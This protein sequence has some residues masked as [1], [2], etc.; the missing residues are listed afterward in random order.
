MKTIIIT[1]PS[2]SGKTFL[3]NKL[4]KLFKNSIV[5]KTDS[6]YRDNFLIKFLSFFIDDIYDRIISIKYYELINTIN[7]IESESNQ[8]ELYYYEFKSKRSIKFKQKMEYHKSEKILIIEGIF[9]HRL[10]I[11]YNDTLNIICEETKEICYKRRLNRDKLERGRSIFEVKKKF[12]KSWNLYFK[13]LEKIINN[14][15]L[16]PVKTKNQQSYSLLI[17]KLQEFIKKT[18]VK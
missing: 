18:K 17:T 16:I 14:I 8:L 5:I 9:S 15:N 11:N 7:A 10:G 13:N 12:S 3:T 2:G 4:V 1:G 6:Y